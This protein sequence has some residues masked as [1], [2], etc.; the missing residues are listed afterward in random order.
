MF[1]PILLAIS[2]LLLLSSAEKEECR[3]EN[4]FCEEIAAFCSDPEFETLFAKDDF[5]EEIAAF[6]SDPEFETLFAK[7]CK[8]TCNFCADSKGP[9]VRAESKE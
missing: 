6:C 4:D 2:L 9:D 3:D 8:K 7:G 5:C 1:Y